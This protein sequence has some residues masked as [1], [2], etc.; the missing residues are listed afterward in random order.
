MYDFNVPFDNN[1]AERDIRMIKIHQKISGTFRTE[2]GAKAFCHMRSYI[3]TARKNT[4]GAMDAMTRLLGDNPF[5]P[6]F[7][8]S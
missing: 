6:T 4:I 3:S 5:I 7:G 2:E 8:S 1:L